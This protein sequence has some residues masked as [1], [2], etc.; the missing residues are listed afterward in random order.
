M[1]SDELITYSIENSDVQKSIIRQAIEYALISIP[2]TFDRLANRNL[3]KNIVNIAKGKLAENYFY[4]FCN[5]HQL[6]IDT[7]SLSTPFYQADKKDFL[8]KGLEWDIKNNF[9]HHE[10][11]LLAPELYLEQMAL[12][13][14]RGPWDQWSKRSRINRQQSKGTGYVFTFMKKSDPKIEKDFLKID[15]NLEQKN[16]LLDLYE[17]YQ[18]KHQTHSPYEMG[19]FWENFRNL[20][21]DFDY[22]ISFFPHLVITGVALMPDFDKFTLIKPSEMTSPYLR[23]IIENMGVKVAELK[24]FEEFAELK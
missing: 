13:P 23:T 22:E 6:A 20:G 1:N 8:F 9:L 14:N 18:G 7:E 21:G 19:F 24:S 16:F 10:L 15:M 2:F 3:T 4:N 17:K 11:P 12:I 5:E